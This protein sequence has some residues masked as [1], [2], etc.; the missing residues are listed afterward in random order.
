MSKS[1]DMHGICQK[2]SVLLTLAL[3]YVAVVIGI[4]L[5]IMSS[6]WMLF[7][8]HFEGPVSQSFPLMS[9]KGEYLW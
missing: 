9:F 1:V 2:L 8:R 3:D 4:F 7:G 6:F 5:I